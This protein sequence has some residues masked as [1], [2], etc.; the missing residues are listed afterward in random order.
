MHG[1]P[2]AGS[3]I[4][5]ARRGML[6]RAASCIA[7][8]GVLLGHSL[9]V[10]SSAQSEPAQSIVFTVPYDDPRIDAR[11]LVRTPEGARAYDARELPVGA[12]HDLTLPAR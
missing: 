6:P 8:E 10:A 9:G 1:A 2:L 3:E 5:V 7:P 11:I 12:R 4:C